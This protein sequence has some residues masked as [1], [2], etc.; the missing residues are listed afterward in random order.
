M[1]ALLSFVYQGCRSSAADDGTAWL[2]N[3]GPPASGSAVG[4]L[5]LVVGDGFE[6]SGAVAVTGA[7]E[8]GEVAHEVVLRGAVPVFLAGRGVDGVAG[9][10]ADDGAVPG[11]NQTGPVG[12]VQG[13]A[14]SVGVPVGPGAGCEADQADD[15]PGRVFAPVDRVDI[16]VASEGR[17]GAFRGR[18][19]GLEFHLVLL[20]RGGVVHGRSR[21]L[22]A[23]RSSMARYPSAA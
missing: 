4:K 13:L 3:G 21:V 15:H 16:N 19:Y 9:T 10:H 23:R 17:R 11:G 1:S 8:H 2:G 5:V 6:P 14:D 7:F 20:K 22:I 18:G 12:D